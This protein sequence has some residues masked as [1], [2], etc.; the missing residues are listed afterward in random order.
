MP[1]TPRTIIIQAKQGWLHFD[2]KSIWEYRDLL[3]LLVWRDF[4]SRYK[5]T[6]LG[7]IWFIIQPILM[8]LLF[9]FIFGRIAQI[10]TDGTPH[11]L[12]YLCGLMSWNYFAQSFSSIS[13][14]F[15]ANAHIYQK[16]YFPRI[17]IPLANLISN[18]FPLLIQLAT[19]LVFFAYYKLSGKWEG[20]PN[21]FGNAIIFYPFIILQASAL[22]LGTGLWMS[23]VTAKYRDLSQLSQFIIQVWMY[24]TPI[25]FP[26]SSVPEAFRWLLMV[27]PMTFIIEATKTL[28]LGVGNIQIQSCTISLALT[29]TVLIS[30][31]LVYQRIERTF[32]DTL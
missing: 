25:I 4:I 28:F 32:V 22:G 21:S 7:P 27:N 18:L 16:V 29:L 9:S 1:P 30:G 6:L 23:A 14:S 8:T 13:G 12:F 10:P 19:F 26:L 31:V 20:A 15:L 2:W 5:Q 24:A 3:L 17:I 11:I